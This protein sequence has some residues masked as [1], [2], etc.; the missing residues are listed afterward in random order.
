M[1]HKNHVVVNHFSGAK[2]DDMYHYKKPTQKKSP[3][4]IITHVGTNDLPSE[5]EPEE[6]A[7][8]IINLAK[9]V[10]TEENKI[11]V[12]SILPR[13]DKHNKKG[14]EV[15]AYLQEKC[16]QNNFP[17]ITHSNINERR[18][19]NSKGLHLNNYGD[20]LLTRNFISFIENS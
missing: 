2:T 5:K 12:S 6:I 19:T 8:N 9:S 20:K 18:H 11:A 13:K 7:N 3:A 16:S 10:K 4:E 15:N 17:F 14:K 1:K